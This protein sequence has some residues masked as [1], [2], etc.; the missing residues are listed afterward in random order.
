[1][2]RKFPLLLLLLEITLL[3]AQTPAP[4]RFTSV[5]ENSH[6]AVY[7]LDLAP[8]T[9]AAVFQGTHDVIWLELN[10]ASVTFAGRDH[11]STADLST[12]DVRFFPEFQLASMANAATAN[13]KGVLIEIKSRGGTLNCGCSA[14][15]ERSVCGCGGGH[16]PELW[17]LGL[18]GITLGGTT[19]RAGQSF[20]GSSVRDDML[21]VA[22]T[23]LDLKD[24]AASDASEIRLAA[25]EARWLPAAAHQFRNL[26]AQPARFV[27]VE[28]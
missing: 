24:E 23:A 11:S 19:L 27:T 3:Q 7:S 9:R 6:V 20:L 10:D 26:G 2:F 5:F 13:A 14:A 22:V 25:G 17:A 16:L 4:A 1:M 12:G 21:L 28:F 15:V 18:G 8:R